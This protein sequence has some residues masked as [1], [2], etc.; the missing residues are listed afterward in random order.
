MEGPENCLIGSDGRVAQQTTL[1][2][3]TVPNL[4]NLVQQLLES[5]RFVRKTAPK[6]I[7]VDF[8]MNRQFGGLALPKIGRSAPLPE[9]TSCIAFA[10]PAEA[11]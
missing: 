10:G 5:K 11:R 2:P 9:C 3:Q 6:R 7:L 1:I 4:H 8:A